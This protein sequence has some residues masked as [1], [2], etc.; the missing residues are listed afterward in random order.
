MSY[1]EGVDAALCCKKCRGSHF[2]NEPKATTAIP[3]RETCLLPCLVRV[4]H[5]NHAVPESP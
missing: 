5:A 4:S 3:L 1:D 2:P